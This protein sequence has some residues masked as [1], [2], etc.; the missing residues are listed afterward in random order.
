MQAAQAGWN[1]TGAMKLGQQAALCTLCC[2]LPCQPASTEELCDNPVNRF[3]STNTDALEQL[4]RDYCS[5]GTCFGE[6]FEVNKANVV[7]LGLRRAKEV[8]SLCAGK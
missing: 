4:R 6:L 2:R 3:C 5:R 8:N 7:I 1:R